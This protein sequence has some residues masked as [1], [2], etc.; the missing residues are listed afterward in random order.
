VWCDIDCNALTVKNSTITGNGKAGIHDEISNG[1]AVISG[2]TIKGNGTLAAAD[3][4]AGLLIM[5]SKNV[6]AHN[7]TFGSNVGHGVEI[8]EDRRAPE[9]GNVKV[10]D[11]TMNG[12]SLRGCK[13][14]GV[15]CY[16]N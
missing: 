16:G 2:N 14:R 11:N 7:N 8:D 15:A 13:Q 12:D 6:D 3:R 10:H 1:P 9:M 4:H 5:S